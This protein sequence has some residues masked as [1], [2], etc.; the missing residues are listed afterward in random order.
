MFFSNLT[1]FFCRRDSDVF[2]ET[3]ELKYDI[4]KYNSI[5][6]MPKEEEAN[7]TNTITHNTKQNNTVYISGLE[8]INAGYNGVITLSEDNKAIKLPLVNVSAVIKE[9]K[10]GEGE[11]KEEVKKA[12]DDIVIEEEDDEDEEEKEQKDENNEEPIFKEEQYIK[13][14][15]AIL[16]PVYENRF[17]E[18]CSNNEDTP[19]TIFE[20]EFDQ[21]YKEDF[22]ITKGIKIFIQDS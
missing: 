11:T 20:V 4:T 10:E 5:E 19:L 17:S 1:M 3:I 14:D 22:F 15:N 2:P 7:D 6:E 21:K 18:G 8:L 9:K 16:I 12:K 13:D